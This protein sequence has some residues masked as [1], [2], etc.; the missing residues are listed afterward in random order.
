MDILQIQRNE[1]WYYMHTCFDIVPWATIFT[2]RHFA[3]YI[4]PM[5]CGDQLADRPD[6]GHVS[7][8]P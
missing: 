3:S 4:H 5:F 2:V 1:F 8:N 7:L 6:S